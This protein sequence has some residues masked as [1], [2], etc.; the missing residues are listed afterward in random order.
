MLKD[1]SSAGIPARVAAM[2]SIA[3]WRMTNN[4]Y[5]LHCRSLTST[6]TANNEGHICCVE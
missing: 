3:I 1:E 4:M 2:S 5:H 6:T